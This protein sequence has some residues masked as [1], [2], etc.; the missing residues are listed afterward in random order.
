MLEFKNYI[1][2][3]SCLYTNPV[4]FSD[5]F[6]SVKFVFPCISRWRITSLTSSFSFSRAQCKLEHSIFDKLDGSN[7]A[8][9][10]P[11]FVPHHSLILHTRVGIH[12]HRQAL[13][14]QRRRHRWFSN[15]YHKP[16]NCQISIPRSSAMKPPPLEMRGYY[17]RETKDPGAG[18]RGSE[19]AKTKA[20]CLPFLISFLKERK[21]KKGRE[22]GR[23]KGRDGGKKITD[24]S[25]DVEKQEP[26]YTAGIGVKQCS[27]FGKPQGSSSKN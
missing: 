7:S 19:R 21:W 26:L 1:G 22:G 27:H 14:G 2:L 20:S 25:K 24:V 4:L 18:Q 8:V 13:W 3:S 9:T 6:S 16:R 11:R 23:K 5:S 10:E 12:V 17:Q 15:W